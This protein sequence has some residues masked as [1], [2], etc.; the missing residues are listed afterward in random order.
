MDWLTRLIG[1]DA[2]TILWWQMAIRGV[3]IFFYTLMLVR[4]GGRRIFG[5]NTSFDIV[6]GVILGSIMS[7][8]LTA[9]AQFLP[10][11]VAGTVL[12]VLHWLLAK[13]ATH[14][15]HL[16]HLIKGTEVLLIKDGQIQQDGLTKTNI[17]E[18]DLLES[19][20]SEGSVAEI[21]QV[22]RAYLERNGKVSVIT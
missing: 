13:L 22:K 21:E 19:L 15:R 18:H 11:L 1:S 17:T 8:A 4:F 7:R 14:N 6:L 20:R 3:L 5:K 16:G 10:T 9:N 12:V 2:D